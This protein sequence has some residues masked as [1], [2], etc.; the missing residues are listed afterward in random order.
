MSLTP[1]S[2]ELRF[3]R[4]P[5]TW[6]RRQDKMYGDFALVPEAKQGPAKRIADPW[7]LRND[8][9]RMEHSEAAALNFLERIGV[10]GVGD[11]ANYEGAT[12]IQGAFGY[13][14]I[15]YPQYPTPMTIEELW[16]EQERW[17]AMLRNPARL[18]AEFSGRPSDG[19]SS[20]DHF[21]FACDTQYKN[22]LL[23]HIEPKPLPH[24]VI[25]PITGRELLIALAW[26]DLVGGSEV[27]VCQNC[28]I[29]F[30]SNRKR[31]FCPPT[32]E[33]AITS[34]CA[35]AAAQRA[36]RK[37]NSSKAKARKKSR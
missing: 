1:I 30:T 14:Y 11:C 28:G 7:A 12:S 27:Q 22:T 29:P 13:R 8:F 4:I 18:R 25:Q 17:K 37:R 21:K 20:Y 35:H 36:Y 3:L 19:A 26:V 24:A 34:P 31:M 10:W 16:D 2:L 33:Y 5:A 32:Q 15:T 9:L 23:T 6:S